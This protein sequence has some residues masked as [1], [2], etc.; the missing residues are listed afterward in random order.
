M[1][2]NHPGNDRPTTGFAALSS[3]VSDVEDTIANAAKPQ[4]GETGGANAQSQSANPTSSFDSPAY[5][6]PVQTG[7]GSK[8]GW[9]VGGLAVAGLIWAANQPSGN[10]SAPAGPEPFSETMPSV[11]MGQSLT[12]DELR[13][14]LAEKVRMDAAR[15]VVNGYDWPQ[16]DRFNAMV[17]DYNSRCGEFRYRP[18]SMS[19]AQDDVNAHRFELEQEGRDRITGA[20]PA[21]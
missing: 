13:Y 2:N 3:Q 15:A 7:N 10:S 14:C 8:V 5:N 16:V 17:A 9:W 6:R 21:Q 11:G 12:T 20:S 19:I 1:S 18:S 4:S